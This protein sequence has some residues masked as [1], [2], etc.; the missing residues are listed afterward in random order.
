MK[1]FMLIMLS[2]FIGIPGTSNH[3]GIHITI[4]AFPITKCFNGKKHSKEGTGIVFA[5]SKYCT[6][7]MNGTISAE[8]KHGKYSTFFFTVHQKISYDVPND[9]CRIDIVCCKKVRIPLVDD[10]DIDI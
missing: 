7:K 2:V 10:N 1:Y 6:E 4:C 3:I 5:A 9:L 8:S